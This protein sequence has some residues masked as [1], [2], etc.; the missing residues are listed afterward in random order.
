VCVASLAAWPAVA[1]AASRS[2]LIAFLAAGVT[3]SSTA[4]SD[5]IEAE[6]AS[7]P[8][9]STAIL[10][11]TQ[12]TYKPAQLLLDIT[13]G[14]R[15][16]YS[17]YSPAY[18]PALALAPFAA[19]S[20]QVQPWAAVRERAAK[21]P[22]LLIPGLLAS[23][24]PGGVAYAGIGSPSGA[25]S[26]QAG[27]ASAAGNLDA[28]IA[29]DRSGRVSAISFGSQSTLL[30]RIARS[31]TSHSLL[32]A[33]LPSGEPGLAALRALAAARPPGELLVV[34]QRAG[35]APGRELLWIAFA[36]LG[37]GGDTLTSQTTEQRGLVAAIDVGP[38]ILAHLGLPIPADM[39]GRPIRLDG[40]FDGSALRGLK[41]R[42]IVIDSRRLPAAA[43]LVAAWA[44]LLGASVL[45]LGGDRR[46]R[47]S[48]ALRVGALALLWAP[49][50]SLIPAAL[51]SS[52]T[53][54]FALIVGVCFALGALADT[55]VPWPRAPAL[56]ALVVVL[57]LTVDALAGTQLL[58][59]SLLGPKPA[60]GARFYGIGNE[61]KSGL[62]VLVFAGAA[63]A[64]YPAVRGRRAALSMACAGVALAV[65]E[66][67]ARIGAGVGGVILVS[68]GAAVACALLLPG[69]L[70]R[71][72]ALLVMVAP[73]MGLI[74][75]AVLDLA[76]A[77]G[78]GHFTGSVLDAR[79][80]GE[81]RDIIVRRY[82]AAWDEL[83]NHLMPVATGLAL[84][85]SA[86]AVRRRER[87]CAPVDSDPAWLAALAGGLTAGVIG[88]LT[89]DSGPVLL[90]VAVFALTCVLAYLWG[91]PRPTAAL[92]NQPGQRTA[93]ESIKAPTTGAMRHRSRAPVRLPRGRDDRLPSLTCASVA[94]WPRLRR[95]ADFEPGCRHTT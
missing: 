68:A 45:P 32:V 2:A 63:G 18:P 51:E 34:I 57:V 12:G 92:S 61:L 20:V 60:F 3:T 21:A 47:R 82:G 86:I 17:A 88:A 73:V 74:A 39:R 36:G 5:A 58:I 78:S 38:T 53:A 26:A 28:T 40:G 31:S 95:P 11:A 84:I 90:V 1:P 91:R 43:W 69:A 80:A 25:S 4:E 35:E 22:Q 81:I 10:S 29:A 7:I 15:V 49:A 56:V 50:A 89:E 46:K 93:Q 72:R 65:V 33:D 87:V 41:A 24:I 6:L 13:Q 19:H 62:A 23:S 54:E 9:L 79:S 75:L 55:L 42:L 76:T 64:L 44:L 8:T 37:P 30:A 16:S 83:K 67:S 85:G 70:S 14:A 77:K 52:R 27:R 66:G 48:W 71:R 94:R 59:R